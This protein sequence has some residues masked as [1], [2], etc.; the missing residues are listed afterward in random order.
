MGPRDRRYVLWQSATLAVA[1]L[2][3]GA[4]LAAAL[5]FQEACH[6]YIQ[7][8]AGYHLD[9]LLVLLPVVCLFGVS[10]ILF[11]ANRRHYQEE[12]LRRE[13]EARFKDIAYSMA[14]RIWET[15]PQGRY[16]YSSSAARRIYGYE[17]EEF[18]G[19]RPVDMMPPE[20]AARVAPLLGE[21]IARREPLVDLENWRLDKNGQPICLLT[22]GVAV[23]DKKGEFRGYRGVDRD[24]TNRKK[25]E[26]DLH[27]LTNFDPLTGLV[28]RAMF[29]E[30]L[31]KA[32][33]RAKR[34]G[35]VVA[36]MFL[37]LDQF[38]NVND[39]LGHPLG[40]LL[41]KEVASRLTAELRQADAVARFG[42]DE[43]AI[44]QADL[45][46]T[47]GI[48]ALAD[49]ILKFISRPYHIEGNKIHITTTIGITTQSPQRPKSVSEL[50]SQ[51]DRALY[52]AK[53]QGRNRFM[54]HDPEME[55]EVRLKVDLLNDLY[56]ALEHNEFRVYYQPQVAVPDGRIIGL[57]ALLRWQ[58]PQRG[59]LP[60]KEFIAPAEDNGLI[61]PVGRW[62]LHE[63]CRQLKEWQDQGL[64]RS[65]HIAVNLSPVQV[66]APEFA[67]TVRT[68][69]AQTGLDSDCLELELTENIL[70]DS[71]PEA[72][73]GLQ[74]LHDEGVRFSIDDFGTG[75]SSLQ[76]LKT[77]PVYKLKI[78]QEFVLDLPRDP[79]DAAIVSAVIGLGNRLDLAVIAEGVETREQLDFLTAEGCKE[80]QGYYFSR[81]QPAKALT[82]LLA[83]GIIK[84]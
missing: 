15:D 69:I 79:N 14:D 65:I 40:D 5:E 25:A 51:A 22:S 77:L 43:F 29:E 63:A 10:F 59:L 35:S 28:N 9:E 21:I 17:P 80:V 4:I 70:M 68:A 33:G 24:I 44:L 37:D 58:H 66:S 60:P 50:M 78:A 53:I 8:L 36:V 46:D 38:K 57:E 31:K 49:R 61:V 18:I 26:S 47:D 39:T 45:P 81:P 41:L 76:Y 20:E 83:K 2:F 16:T 13:S 64:S 52:R 73:R 56:R 54:F 7:G 75:Y 30:H 12:S 42:G 23:L 19:K 71:T 84:K 62:V 34:E 82:P 32:L 3:S 48:G 74:A 55:R 72:L 67:P 1:F 11:R 6:L 27:R